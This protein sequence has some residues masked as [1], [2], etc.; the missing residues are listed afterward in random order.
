MTNPKL[1]YDFLLDAV[2]KS[3][4]RIALLL[5]SD[6]LTYSMLNK[7]TDNLADFLNGIGIG[8]G[9]RLII[10]NE[11]PVQASIA[12]WAALKADAIVVPV[13]NQIKVEKL[14]YILN[15]CRAELIFAGNQTILVA[16]QAVKLINESLKIICPKEPNII[17]RK[18][19]PNIFYWQDILNQK[20]L[21]SSVSLRRLNIELDLACIIYTSGS[22]GEPKGV[23]LTHRNMISAS[24]SVSA[25]LSINDTDVILNCLPLSFDY[26]LYQIIMACQ[27]NASVVFDSIVFPSKVFQT[28]NQFSCTLFPVVPS[29]ISLLGKYKLVDL[30]SLTSSIRAVTSTAS[31]L[32][33]NHIRTI[34]QLFPDSM[35]FSMYGLTECQRCSYLP[36]CDLD[37]KPGSVGKAIPNTELWVVDE[38]NNRLAP[39]QAG[40]LVVRGPTVM[41]GYWGKAE[42]TNRKLRTGS[43][44]GDTLLYTGDIC[45]LDEEGYLYFVGRM[46][47]ILKINGQK[48]AP[49]EIESA[50]MSCQGINEACVVGFAD[51]SHE[52]I[53][54]AFVVLTATT[55]LTPS[56]I[57]LELNQFLEPNMMPKK[58]KIL[59]EFPKLPSGKV[60]K[61]SILTHLQG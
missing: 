23:M 1:V 16:L 47:D 12:F 24:D 9:S 45:R 54:S 39:N 41:A 38:S 58:I 25:Y 35:I 61:L 46:D 8:R 14:C 53:I 7:L 43:H 22:T 5:G 52:L 59:D 50:L 19:S 49:K 10:Y 44:F 57:M 34:Q 56:E 30:V 28:I 6:K 17:S 51:D 26:G 3:P 36:P 18:R 4:E 31:P 48:V 37:R 33:L 27:H 13:S 40:Q 29:M 20:L 55:N 32:F 60:D 15:D 2:D 11:D 21:S 42:E